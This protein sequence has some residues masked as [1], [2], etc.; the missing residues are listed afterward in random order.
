MR[1]GR[2]ST[3]SSRG[4]GMDSQDQQIAALIAERDRAV[5]HGLE[6]AARLSFVCSRDI[7][8]TTEA[9]RAALVQRV[10]E[11]EALV[12]A[13]LAVRGEGPQEEVLSSPSV[14]REPQPH[15][16]RRVG[17]TR[18]AWLME[19][20][21]AQDAGG[22]RNARA[23]TLVY[24]DG[25]HA[26]SFTTD[27]YA[28]VQWSSE[29]A[30]MEQCPPKDYCQWGWRYVEHGFIGEGPVLQAPSLSPRTPAEEPPA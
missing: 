25:G 22:L 8:N 26:E 17:S 14:S 12:S 15:E 23:G 27:P 18:F 16:S 10:N 29:A 19:R 6:L 21:L 5:A 20:R 13:L 2:T 28:A 24:W 30:A 4:K 11:L 7:D 3:R 9:A 1:A